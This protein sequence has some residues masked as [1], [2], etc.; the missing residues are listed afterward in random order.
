VWMGS[1][2]GSAEGGVRIENEEELA[3]FLMRRGE[4]ERP[5]SLLRITL[6]GRQRRP[7]RIPKLAQPSPPDAVVAAADILRSQT[8]GFLLREAFRVLSA[9]RKTDPLSTAFSQPFSTQFREIANLLLSSTLHH[10]L[11][12]RESLEG[13]LPPSVLAQKLLKGDERSRLQISY[14]PW[15]RTLEE[16]EEKV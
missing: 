13:G 6:L 15:L 9:A 8:E 12:E 16:D 2:E 4:R 10:E 7:S 11:L 1:P 14:R 3:E 5:E